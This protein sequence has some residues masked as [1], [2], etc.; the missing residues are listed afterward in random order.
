METRPQT[1]KE[2]FKTLQIIYYSLIAGQVFFGLVSVII[3]QM[4][5]LNSGLEILKDIFLYIV[6]VIIISGLLVGRRLF[7]NNMKTASSR[8][9]LI[10]KMADYRASCILKYALLEGPSFLAIIIFLVTGD[11]LFLGMTGLIIA[12]FLTM[13]PTK[14]YAVRNLELNPYEEQKIHDDNAVI[15]EIKFEK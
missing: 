9:G 8:A 11:I 2:Y 7:K 6:P 5:N 14:E 15:S 12:I 4:I 10:E 3:N 13:K 1:S